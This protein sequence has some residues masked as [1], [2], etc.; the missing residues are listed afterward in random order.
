MYLYNH[1]GFVTRNDLIQYQ[2][3]HLSQT[4]LVNKRRLDAANYFVPGEPCPDGSWGVIVCGVTSV[5][6][7][8]SEH[9]LDTSSQKPPRFSVRD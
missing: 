9:V 4:S 1:G 6:A 3:I 7:I 2:K 8:F 5:Q